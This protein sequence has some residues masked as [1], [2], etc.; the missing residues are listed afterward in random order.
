MISLLSAGL[1]FPLAVTAVSVGCALLLEQA[2]GVRLPAGLLP[3]AGFAVV[4]VASHIAT[5]WDA[6]AELALPV[7]LALAVAGFALSLPLRDRGIEWWA[8]AAGC[9]V[10]G[11]LRR[12]RG[13]LRRRDLRRLHQ[14]RRHRHVAG[15]D[16]PADGARPGLERIGALVVRGRA[17]R[18]PQ[19]R[20]SGGR[21][22]PAR[23]RGQAGRA[24]RG[25]GV[26][27]LPGPAGR[28][29]GPRALRPR[30]PCDRLAAVARAGRDGR[31]PAGAVVRLLAVGRGQGARR[32]VGRR[33]A[34]GAARAPV[35]GTGQR[36]FGAAARIRERSVARGA[37]L[38]RDRLACAA[39]DPRRDRARAGTRRQDRARGR[40]RVRGR[41]RS[42]RGP[43]AVAG[44][45]F[46]GIRRAARS[47]ADTHS[48]TS[49]KSWETWS[50]RSA[51][52]S[53]PV[54]GRSGTSASSRPTSRPPTS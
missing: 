42:A 50:S 6:T 7:V 22:S 12:T 30:G 40:P 26:P 15:H 19:H 51:A 8:V 13:A 39:A 28:V 3:A 29:H 1:L 31:E 44:G 14:A 32:G 17:R 45:D 2:A 23:H 20:I 52:C 43:H 46:P 38:R 27:A 33:A 25:L 21:V 4:L 48:R 41:D 49:P 54:S 37:Q 47:R 18:Q 53:S 16:R 10:Y 36:V 11:C 24:G 5:A 34:R 35:R 9:A